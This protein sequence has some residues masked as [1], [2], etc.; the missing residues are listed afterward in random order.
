MWHKLNGKWYWTGEESPTHDPLG[1]KFYD[2][3]EDG[4]ARGVGDEFF[5]KG[6]RS[7]NGST[8][9]VLLVAL[10]SAMFILSVFWDAFLAEG[11][12]NLFG[13]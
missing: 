1:N 9:L 6:E 7:R 4:F 12:R 8:I 2:V 10:L 5:S 13:G 11:L 3:D